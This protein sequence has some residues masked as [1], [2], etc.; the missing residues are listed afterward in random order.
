MCSDSVFEIIY[1]VK[2]IMQKKLFYPWR[3]LGQIDP[4]CSPRINSLQKSF[5]N[6]NKYN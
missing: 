4:V 3:K 1:R 5:C 2:I 6:I